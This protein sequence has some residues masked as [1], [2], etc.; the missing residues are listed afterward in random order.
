MTGSNNLDRDKGTPYTNSA[1]K[2]E[3]SMINKETWSTLQVKTILVAMAM[4]M[5]P[6][7]GGGGGGVWL[8]LRSRIESLSLI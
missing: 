7:W 3:I 4:A 8:K 2:L 6:W 1:L 5:G